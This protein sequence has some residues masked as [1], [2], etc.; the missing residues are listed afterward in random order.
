[1]ESTRSPS[2][3]ESQNTA[4]HIR[5][6]GTHAN[7]GSDLLHSSRFH[8]ILSAGAACSAVAPV[9]SSALRVALH[10]AESDF[11]CRISSL[12]FLYPYSRASM[13]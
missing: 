7:F 12:Q 1:M 6:S 2:F 8:K 3:P 10:A 4:L 9:A 11:T 5:K 13:R